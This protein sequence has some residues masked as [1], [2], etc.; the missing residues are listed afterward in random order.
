MQHYIIN[1]SKQNN[2]N[3]DDWITNEFIECIEF[4]L[5]VKLYNH[6]ICISITLKTNI[7][8]TFKNL[9][10]KDEKFGK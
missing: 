8:V 4:P 1:F 5:M 9:Q 6:H 10:T 7:L 2:I 3:Q